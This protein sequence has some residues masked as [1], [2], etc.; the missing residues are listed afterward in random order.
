MTRFCHASLDRIIIVLLLFFSIRSLGYS[1]AVRSRFS[2]GFGFGNGPIWMDDVEC[3][4]N[5]TRLDQCSFPGWGIQDCYHWQDAGVVCDS[6][7]A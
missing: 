3:T 5:E 1:A 4:G 7:F 6:E 2:S